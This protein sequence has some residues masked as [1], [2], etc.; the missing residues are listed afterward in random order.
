MRAIN[1]LLILFALTSCALPAVSPEGA[2]VK[3]VPKS[4]CPA[5]GHFMSFR[6]DDYNA[7][8]YESYKKQE[9]VYALDKARDRASKMGGD[10][11]VEVYSIADHPTRMIMA[12]YSV[13]KCRN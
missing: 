7:L 10:Q 12:F 8:N 11:V 4:A 3:A 2:R 13:H 6:N 1:C 9:D 5:V